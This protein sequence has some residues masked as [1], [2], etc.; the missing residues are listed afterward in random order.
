MVFE[1]RLPGADDLVMELELIEVL[2]LL[3]LHDVLRG[4]VELG[5]AHTGL[6]QVGGAGVIEQRQG[7]AHAGP[8][9]GCGDALL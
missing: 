4:D 7:A 3:A 1:K 8:D 6:G 5:R 2:D 9:G